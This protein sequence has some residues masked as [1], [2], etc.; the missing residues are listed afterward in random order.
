MSLNNS[1]GHL[2]VQYMT[3]NFLMKKTLKEPVRVYAVNLSNKNNDYKFETIENLEQFR[4]LKLLNL[5]FNR[6]CRISGLSTLCHLTVLNISNNCLTSLDGIQSLSN[7]LVLKANENQITFIP[8]WLPKRL[9]KLKTIHLHCNKIDALHQITNLRSLPNLTVFTFEGNPAVNQLIIN[10]CNSSSSDEAVA[11]NSIEKFDVQSLYRIFVIF[12]LCSLILLDNKEVLPFER[13]VAE[14]RFSQVEISRCLKKL[15]T[16]ESQ[17]KEVETKNSLLEKN[18]LHEQSQL[19]EALHK[20]KLENDVISHLKEELCAKDKLLHLKSEELA[21]ACLKHFELEQE[22]AFHKIDE[23]LGLV[24]SYLTKPNNSPYIHHIQDT[25][26]QP[27]LGKCMFRRVPTNISSNNR[28]NKYSSENIIKALRKIHLNNIDY[29]KSHLKSCFNS[30]KLESARSDNNDNYNVTDPCT[31]AIVPPTDLSREHNTELQCNMTSLNDNPSHL[32][33]PNS[34][35]SRSSS[36]NKLSHEETR[37]S[38]TP[39][40][41]LANMKS[42]DVFEKKETTTSSQS[43]DNLPRKSSEQVDV[44]QIRIKLSK[45]QSELLQLR[46]DELNIQNNVDN[47]SNQSKPL[48]AV[49]FTTDDLNNRIRMLEK[50]L[51]KMWTM[52]HLIKSES[53]ENGLDNRDNITNSHLNSSVTVPR[54]TSEKIEYA[55]LSKSDKNP[56]Y[57]SYELLRENSAHR[58]RERRLS[59]PNKNIDPR[60]IVS[61]GHFTHGNGTTSVGSELD[62]CEEFVDSPRKSDCSKMKGSHQ[63]ILSHDN[64]LRS[65]TPSTPSS[66]T[67]GTGRSAL[68]SVLT[69]RANDMP[70][71]NHLNKSFASINVRD[72]VDHLKRTSCKDVHETVDNCIPSE[73]TASSIVYNAHPNVP[74]VLSCARGSG[75][76]D[77][78]PT[79]SHAG[80]S[81]QLSDSSQSHAYAENTKD[82]NTEKFIRPVNPNIQQPGNPHRQRPDNF[83]KYHISRLPKP[84]PTRTLSRGSDTLQFSDRACSYN[85]K[86]KKSSSK[87]RSC[88]DYS[89]MRSCVKAKCTRKKHKVIRSCSE[90]NKSEKIM[91]DSNNSSQNYSLSDHAEEL[92][93]LIMMSRDACSQEVDRIRADLTRIRKANSRRHTNLDHCRQGSNQ[94]IY[95]DC[96]RSMRN[97][98]DT[99]KTRYSPAGDDNE[100]C[101]FTEIQP[102]AYK[103]QSRTNFHQ[104]SSENNNDRSF[105]PNHPQSKPQIRR[106][107][108]HTR[109]I[110]DNDYNGFDVNDRR[111]GNSDSNNDPCEVDDDYDHQ[112][113]FFHRCPDYKRPTDPVNYN[114][115]WSNKVLDSSWNTDQKNLNRS[116]S[117]PRPTSLHKSRVIARRPR[118]RSIPRDLPMYT[119]FSSCHNGTYGRKYSRRH[120]LDYAHYN[121]KQSVLRSSATS[122]LNDNDYRDTDPTSEAAALIHLTDELLGLR[123]GLKRTREA[124]SERL[125]VALRHISLLELELQRQRCLNHDAEVARQREVERLRWEKRLAA[126]VS[127]LKHCQANLSNLRDQVDRLEASKKISDQSDLKLERQQLKLDQTKATLDA[128][129]EAITRLNSLLTS[130]LGL[131]PNDVSPSDLQRLQ[132]GLLDLHKHMQPEYNNQCCHQQ[133]ESNSIHPRQILHRS[134]S[135]MTGLTVPGNERMNRGDWVDSNI[136]PAPITQP[137]SANH[138]LYCNVPEHHDLE[139]CLGQL[140]SKIEELFD[141]QEIAQNKLRHSMKIRRKLECQLEEQDS[142]I[143]RIKSELITCQEDLKIAKQ[144]V[145]RLSCEKEAAQKSKHDQM[146][147]IVTDLATLEATVC[148]RRSELTALDTNIQN[149]DQQL[150]IIKAQAKEAVSKY[151]EAKREY[152]ALKSQLDMIRSEKSLADEN[153]EQI[154]TKVSK[155]NLQIERLESSKSN[156]E[157]QLTQLEDAVNIK[158]LEYNQLLPNLSELETRLTRTQHDIQVGAERLRS[159]YHLRLE[160]ERLS[161]TR[162]AELTRLAR[163]IEE[164]KLRLELLVQDTETKK[165]ELEQIKAEKRR[166]L[167]NSNSVVRDLANQAANKQ[168]E[169]NETQASLSASL[170]E[171]ERILQSVKTLRLE[172][173][174][175]R[176]ELE[177]EQKSVAELTALVTRQKRQFEHLTEMSHLEESRILSLSSQ[178]RDLINQLEKLQVQLNEEKEELREREAAKIR[179]NAEYESVRKDVVREQSELERIL[180]EK[181]QIE[182]ELIHLRQERDITKTQWHSF[183]LKIKE[184]ENQNTQLNDSISEATSVLARV[185]A[186][187]EAA[188]NELRQKNIECNAALA[189]CDRMFKQT[190]DTRDEFN[191]A[192]ERLRK[193]NDLKQSIESILT[194]QRRQRVL[195]SDELNHLEEAVH[196][197]RLAKQLADESRQASEEALR[198]AVNK[199]NKMQTEKKVLEEIYRKRSLSDNHLELD[200][201]RNMKD[202]ELFHLDERLRNTRQHLESVELELSEKSSKLNEISEKLHSLQ[203]EYINKEQAKRNYP[204]LEKELEK[205]K[206]QQNTSPLNNVNKHITCNHQFSELKVDNM[207]RLHDNN[208]LQ[209]LMDTKSALVAAQRESKRLKRRTAREVAELERVAEEQCNRA[210]DLTEQLS[211]AKRQYAQLKSQIATYGILMDE[212][213]T[214]ASQTELTEHSKRLEAALSAVRAELEQHN[215]TNTSLDENGFIGSRLFEVI[216]PESDCRVVKDRLLNDHESQEIIDPNYSSNGLQKS[217]LLLTNSFHELGYSPNNF[218]SIQSLTG[219]LDGLYK[220][221]NNIPHILCPS[222]DTGHVDE[223]GTNYTTSGLGSSLN[224]GTQMEGNGSAQEISTI[225]SPSTLEGSKPLKNDW[226]ANRNGDSPV[227]QQR[228]HTESEQLTISASAQQSHKPRHSKSG[229]SRARL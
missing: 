100:E 89:L 117:N 179:K 21:R 62:S 130:L 201:L 101:N 55:D 69:P 5:S 196:T 148:Q 24:A 1:K 218:H 199:L 175:I 106:L 71:T 38:S 228:S 10:T 143:N 33:R 214:I 133:K 6:I 178:Q 189:D 172:R 27:Y 103:S 150:S 60:Q 78:F 29:D 51:S 36:P 15:D 195:L 121:P 95:A 41:L 107:L 80:V 4:E 56:E 190:S 53:N 3:P 160:D 76:G 132:V 221:S 156:L 54:S 145:T 184:L 67:T 224:P 192:E 207:A 123:Q 142:V 7:L 47:T 82:I 49:N 158:K 43:E 198:S 87:C 52:T 74:N 129:K 180:M 61:S 166:E 188:S 12:H 66:R 83:K 13:Q 162:Q 219:S 186:E 131:N 181:E 151:E 37:R 208:L 144:E 11:N 194:E 91:T 124:N 28:L 211:M 164:D 2:C 110:D 30:A 209:A 229:C 215:M 73:S 92:L 140:Q 226:K 50:E 183:Q 112:M 119:T 14:Q 171:K 86:S 99:L 154:L 155:A 202:N 90:S 19:S 68:L 96:I 205:T 146:A 176:T 138:Q 167:E 23:K 182:L 108:P 116:S 34:A 147:S 177:Q 85:R 135:L 139:D 200:S 213:I 25:G 225:L 152:D 111:N 227:G 8:K 93:N 127:E 204:E 153:L 197:G 187:S 9:P 20:R 97:H 35:P 206:Q 125:E 32:L 46:A 223:P 48:K 212:V 31:A 122:L 193:A 39:D 42:S 40:K 98:V 70:T 63:S 72:T 217:L 168:Q 26:D 157:N 169:L 128:Q 222:S 118:T 88:R 44:E 58:Q 84:H 104:Y 137:S 120:S 191:I 22:L 81:R 114:G 75:V 16:Y 17:L 163:Q 102:A 165:G 45:L 105:N 173:D 161:A 59:L 77:S 174:N 210:G 220:K 159:D 134:Q 18:L 149:S 113:N 126:T 185:R 141:Q 115:H 94:N 65:V 109:S 79:P 203:N 216:N 64:A 57:F 170:D 136:T